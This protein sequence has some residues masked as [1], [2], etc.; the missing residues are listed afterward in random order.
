MSE[1]SGLAYDRST[2]W[3]GAVELTE[4]EAISLQRT[5]TRLDHLRAFLH[6]QRPPSVGTS[7]QEWFAYLA[8]FKAI[9]G[10]F[11]ND[12]S[13]VSCLMAK[14]YLTDRLQLPPFDVA[15][16]AQGASGLDIDERTTTGER[17]IG[18]IKTTTPYQKI[19][20]G[21]AQI[22]ALRKDF[23]K[24]QA[25]DAAHKYMFVTDV[26]AFDALKRGFGAEL[27][28]VTIVCLSSGDEYMHAP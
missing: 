2:A 10:N 14:D 17:V 13:L 27:Q 25:N 22:T 20:F 19:R 9:L 26:T 11:S 12:L 3:T 24:L 1:T 21:A 7:P 28:G 6:D 16:K 5:A 15:E 4:N 8:E 23:A 18:E